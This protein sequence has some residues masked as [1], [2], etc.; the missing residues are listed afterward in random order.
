VRHHQHAGL[1]I[2]LKAPKPNAAPVSPEQRDWIAAMLRQGYA[3]HVAYG[4][5]HAVEIINHYYGIES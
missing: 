5:T 4:W 1:W 2:E 3:A